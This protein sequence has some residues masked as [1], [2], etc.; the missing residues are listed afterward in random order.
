MLGMREPRPQMCALWLKESRLSYRIH[1][2]INR[3]L[4]DIDVNDRNS[5]VDWLGGEMPDAHQ[6]PR[7]LA[8]T[9]PFGVGSRDGPVTRFSRLST[10]FSKIYWQPVS[11]LPERAR[12]ATNTFIPT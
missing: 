7:N 11:P 9:K 10:R 1:K 2:E 4:Y 8:R 12:I 5:G 6:S 3:A